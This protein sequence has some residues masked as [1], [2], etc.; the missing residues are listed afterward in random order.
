MRYDVGRDLSW[1]AKAFLDLVWPRIAPWLRGGELVPVESATAASLQA[2]FD[3]L[4]GIDAWHLCHEQRAMRGI[5]SRIQ[6]T[7]DGYEPYNTFTIR[8]KRSSG[9]ETEFSKRLAAIRDREGGWLYP[10]LTCQAYIDQRKE[11]LLSC[12]VVRTEHLYVYADE[13]LDHG[14]EQA[15]IKA[16][17]ADANEFIVVKWSSLR[18]DGVGV[19]TYTS[20]T[21][22]GV[23]RL[24]LTRQE[25]DLM[26]DATLF[27]QGSFA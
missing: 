11:R 20:P 14:G 7:A 21:V 17:G 19:K 23:P 3:T 9:A 2:T 10:H 5:A 4:A 8:Y 27:V 6:T 12:A 15:Y 25:P 26:A 13:W 22:M 18:A 24:I 1:S 16:N